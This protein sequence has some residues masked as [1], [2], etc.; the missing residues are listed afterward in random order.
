MRKP[1]SEEVAAASTLQGLTAH[2]LLHESYAVQPGDKVLVHA[3]A[4][5]VGLLA[6][7]NGRDRVTRGG[8]TVDGQP[9]DPTGTS[10]SNWS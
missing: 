6:Y 5:G 10:K 2:Y 3:A 4:G 1:T 8:V 7:R 9:D